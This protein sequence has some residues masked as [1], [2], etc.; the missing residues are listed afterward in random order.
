MVK[1]GAIAAEQYDVHGD[2][3]I[4]NTTADSVPRYG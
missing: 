4:R 2:I 3:R 1:Q